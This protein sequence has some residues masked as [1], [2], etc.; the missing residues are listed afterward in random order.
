MTISP[1]LFTNQINLTCDKYQSVLGKL[2][3]KP[4]DETIKATDQSIEIVGIVGRLWQT[5]KGWLGFTNY[6]DPIKVNYQLLRVLNHG[7]THHYFDDQKVK[8]LLT[9]VKNTLIQDEGNRYREI[10]D[11]ITL[12]TT[13]IPSNMPSSQRE[14][15]SLLLNRKITLYRQ[16]H[17]EEL[18]E[19]FW[20]TIYHR[21]FPVIEEEACVKF[22]K[23]QS[24][25]AEGRHEEAIELLTE[26]TQSDPAHREWLPPLANAHFSRA[27]QLMTTTRRYGEAVT[28]LERAIEIIPESPDWP[29]TLGNACF[30]YAEQLIGSGSY[31]EAVIYFEKALRLTP[32]NKTNTLSSRI[33]IIHLLQALKNGNISQA[34]EIAKNHAKTHRLP[35]KQFL[36]LYK[37]DL[38]TCRRQ[39][40]PTTAQSGQFYILLAQ[41]END[42]NSAKDFLTEAINLLTPNTASLEIDPDLAH[43]LI[44][45][46]IERGRR[47]HQ[48]G[49]IVESIADL[50]AANLLFQSAQQLP[51][52]TKLQLSLILTEFAQQLTDSF[53]G[54]FPELA[55]QTEMILKELTKNNPIEQARHWFAIHTLQQSNPLQALE[56]AE[57]ALK[58]VPTNPAYS[59][60]VGSLSLTQASHKYQA[61]RY[62]EAIPFFKRAFELNPQDGSLLFRLANALNETAQWQEG[63]KYC[64]TLVEK[65]PEDAEA[66]MLYSSILT[67]QGKENEAIKQAREAVRLVPNSLKAFE[68]LLDI[69]ESVDDLP[70]N[71]PLAASQNLL[72]IR[73]QDW[74]FHTLLGLLNIK[75]K[76]ESM[77]GQHFDIAVSQNPPQ[78][79]PWVKS[80]QIKLKQKKYFEALPLF[81]KAAKLP[82]Y[83]GKSNPFAEEMSTCY[84]GI[85]ANNCTLYHYEEALRNYRQAMTLTKQQSSKDA[86]LSDLINLGRRVFG[87]NPGLAYSIYKEVL[88]LLSPKVVNSS[89]WTEILLTLA[90]ESINL[91]KHREAETY[92]LSAQQKSPH[93]ENVLRVLCRFYTEIGDNGK[94]ELTLRNMIKAGY[95]KPKE[96]IDLANFC[97][98]KGDYD[99]ALQLC[100][101]AKAADSSKQHDAEFHRI[102]ASL[103]KKYESSKQ[104]KKAIDC[105]R[106]SLET[107]GNYSEDIDPIVKQLVESATSNYRFQKAFAIDMYVLAANQFRHSSLP[108]AEKKRVWNLLAAETERTGGFTKA[109]P[110]YEQSLRI[111]PKNPEMLDRLINHYTTSNNTKS[112]EEWLIIAKTQYPTDS[113]WIILLGNH[114]KNIGDPT[115][116]AQEFQEALKFANKDQLEMLLIE[117]VKINPNDD[118]THLALGDLYMEKGCYEKALE[119]FKLA[120]QHRVAGWFYTS[121]DAENKIY[122][123]LF[124]LGTKYAT[125]RQYQKVVDYCTEALGI[126][127]KDPH[128]VD[129]IIR[130]L[131]DI[132]AVISSTQPDLVNRMY[133]LA[134]VNFDKTSLDNPTK[135]NILKWLASNAQRRADYSKAV[136]LYE[137]YLQIDPRA[138]DAIKTDYV[139]A[140]I[141]AGNSDSRLARH[142]PGCVLKAVIDL[143]NS[144]LTSPDIADITRTLGWWHGENSTDNINLKKCAEPASGARAIREKGFMVI[145]LIGKAYQSKGLPRHLSDDL[146]AL[147]TLI[148]G[149]PEEANDNFPATRQAIAH[150]LKAHQLSSNEYNR[151]Y[152]EH[153]KNLIEAHT[154]VGDYAKACDCYRE[155]KVRFPLAEIN[156]AP[157]VIV[158]LTKQLLATNQLKEA[159]TTIDEAT[160]KFPLNELLKQEKSCVYVAFGNELLRRG[161]QEQALEKYELAISCS[162]QAPAGAFFKASEIYHELLKIGAQNAY[163]NKLIHY[164]KEAAARDPSNAMYQFKC[165]KSLYFTSQTPYHCDELPYFRKAVELDKTNIEYA[166]GLA[167]SLQKQVENGHVHLEKELN[168]AFVHFKTIGGD[169]RHNDWTID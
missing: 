134:F 3:G 163:N 167:M 72:E 54:S 49:N 59:A 88:P 114:Y 119:S 1:D 152:G 35:I 124:L 14:P 145:Q 82:P 48:S 20:A 26:A 141:G 34:L 32:Q 166:F 95:G 161:G 116:A 155:L 131:L 87:E 122:D 22:Q 107:A 110:F 139:R 66:R 94:L 121:T 164:R 113:K 15:P 142:D 60:A 160:K 69:A 130:S 165:G 133:T 118:A 158:H 21:F 9:E 17:S 12:L 71:H 98:N 138:V 74:C 36:E 123:C 45:A 81:E 91:G 79:E 168:D 169:I 148:N 149:M 63:E 62:Q 109:C 78:A 140:S 126:F 18:K 162:K 92:L 76:N 99:E 132:S 28:N 57:E 13:P 115:R 24:A 112:A 25:A 135:L 37:T 80:G 125:A 58:L 27:Q 102:F 68:Q 43:T 67:G 52:T 11:I 6:A 143:T 29:Q 104:L 157:E 56:A 40:Q 100:E 30:A 55:L 41:G 23:G 96:Y 53:S 128:K 38:V 90:K 2:A 108:D 111:D 89:E 153:H 105:F 5:V 129:K 97:I 85:A 50:T 4:K 120:K 10:A 144:V 154:R 75:Q 46:H 106:L 44:S 159:F 42:P 117:T 73:P 86:V 8:T 156:L 7:A 83:T 137:H 51:V 16:N 31:T 147:K 65:H 77:A 93:D 61:L 84:R 47:I 39:I 70:A 64:K 151:E 33:G 103:A 150:Y 19:D 127:P 146:D 101:T 136:E